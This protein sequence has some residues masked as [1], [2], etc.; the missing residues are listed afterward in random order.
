MPY[1]AA[2]KAFFGLCSSPKG[3]SKARSKC[4]PM[5]EARK[6]AHEASMY[7]TKPA[8]RKRKRGGRA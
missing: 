7:P 5:D 3:R 4:P 6:L 2:A 8:K 1:T